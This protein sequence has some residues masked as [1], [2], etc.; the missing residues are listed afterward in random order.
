MYVIGDIHGMVNELEEKLKLIKLDSKEENP[1][2]V[3]LGDYIDRGNDSKKVIDILCSLK[4]CVFLK[5]NHED[6]LIKALKNKKYNTWLSL[7]GYKTVLSYGIKKLNNLDD[8][9][10]SLDDEYDMANF[11]L[12]EN[13]MEFLNNLKNFHETENFYFCHGGVN[14]NLPLDMQD[15]NSLLYGNNR[16]HYGEQNVVYDKKIVYG[17][18]AREDV[19]VENNRICIDTGCGFKENAKLSVLKIEGKNFVLL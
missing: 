3:F 17:H 5:G 12:P 1:E 19:L 9:S 15:W 18:Y 8:D 13:H 16:F 11:K 2:I 10:Y 6:M 7:G 14:P 4:N